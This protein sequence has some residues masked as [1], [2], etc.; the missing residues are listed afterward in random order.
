MVRAFE[1]NA[2]GVRIVITLIA[3]GLIV[4]FTFAAMT[5]PPSQVFAQGAFPAP[6]P[7]QTG[8]PASSPVPFFP[9]ANAEARSDACMKE[10]VP[11]REEAEER[12]RLIKVASDR[13]APADEAC[14]LLGNFIQSEIKMIKYIEANSARCG[15]PSQI[16]DQFSAGHKKTEAMRTKVCRAAQ[17][18]PPHGPGLSEVLSGPERE[19][20]GLVGD[21]PRLD[22]R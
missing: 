6:L 5:L 8:A 20:A 22:R 7:G 9:P 14:K 13:H 3:R 2:N 12:G 4:P 10:F 19:P 18:A 11:L 21:F 15:I 16:A 17:D 1:I